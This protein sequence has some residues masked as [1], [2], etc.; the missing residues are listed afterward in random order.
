[1]LD[2]ILGAAGGILGAITGA[3]D[4]KKDRKLQKDAMQHGISWRVR[5]AQE[6]GIHPLYAL[7]APTFNPSPV[8]AGGNDFASIGQDIGRAAMAYSSKP[9]K[10]A[11]AM[12]ALALERGSLEN[13]L[14]RSQIRKLNQPG[15]PPG[16]PQD[17]KVFPKGPLDELAK[18]APQ[19]TITLGGTDL[20]VPPGNTMGQDL[21]NLFGD[22]DFVN[23]PN[24]MHLI[25]YNMQPGG[26]LEPI[27]I[28]HSRQFVRWMWKKLGYKK[29]YYDRVPQE[30]K[31]WPSWMRFS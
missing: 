30:G 3:S 28:R 18:T 31:R 27:G 9:D 5:D 12:Q 16:L 26:A 1:M 2:S 21:E 13:E 23:Y 14:L 6:A 15:T 20:K 29:L 7:G 25:D 8:G 17:G 11:A 24:I 22:S 4:R 19:Q 10:A